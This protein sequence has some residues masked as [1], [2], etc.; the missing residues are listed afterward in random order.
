MT[1]R[2]RLILASAA[3]AAGAAFPAM[4]DMGMAK[5]GIRVNEKGRTL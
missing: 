5:D 3:L 4:A 1:R 2:L